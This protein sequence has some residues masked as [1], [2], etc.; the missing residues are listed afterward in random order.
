M[1]SVKRVTQ[2]P[3]KW[4]LPNLHRR[5]INELQILHF[6]GSLTVTCFQLLLGNRPHLPPEVPLSPWKQPTILQAKDAPARVY[7]EALRREGHLS[8]TFHLLFYQSSSCTQFSVITFFI[9]DLFCTF[10]CFFIYYRK[11]KLKKQSVF[12]KPRRKNVRNC[13]R[14]AER[15]TAGHPTSK[16]PLSWQLFPMAL[17]IDGHSVGGCYFLIYNEASFSA[18]RSLPFWLC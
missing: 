13:I 3:D 1:Y 12:S 4:N 11:I 15:T 5:H 10:V 7:T 8:G 2:R 9:Q 16:I 18:W 17:Y 14:C 6:H